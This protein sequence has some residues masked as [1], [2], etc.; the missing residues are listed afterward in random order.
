MFKRS[1]DEFVGKKVV[2]LSYSS[3]I[4]GPSDSNNICKESSTNINCVLIEQRIVMNYTPCDDA[5]ESME[6]IGRRIKP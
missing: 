4:L 1:F 3:A 2:S 5:V 6:S